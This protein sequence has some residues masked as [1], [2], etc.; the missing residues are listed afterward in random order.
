M[1][2]WQINLYFHHFTL[3]VAW[4]VCCFVRQQ[5]LVYCLKHNSPSPALAKP[6]FTVPACRAVIQAGITSASLPAA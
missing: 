3:E 5:V 1:F 4:L 2:L 6:V